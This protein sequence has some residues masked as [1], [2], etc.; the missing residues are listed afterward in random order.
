MLLQQESRPHM[1]MVGD[2]AL[3]FPCLA[4]EVV[5]SESFPAVDS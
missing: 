5:E 1:H 2:L 3:R 4:S